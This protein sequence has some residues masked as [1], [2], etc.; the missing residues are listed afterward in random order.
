A[1]ATAHDLTK[2][3]DHQLGQ[4]S[5]LRQLAYQ[6]IVAEGLHDLTIAQHI[7][8]AMFYRGLQ[9]HEAVEIL[10]KHRLVED[11]RVLVRV[12]LEPMVNSAYMLIVGDDETARDFVKYPRFWNYFLMRDLKAIDESRFRKHVPVELEEDVRKEYEALLLRFKN[13]RNGEWCVDAKLYQ[14]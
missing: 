9:T 12:L 7:A 5:E 10:M 2:D 13:R 14:R 1:I 8:L 11:A 6:V 3:F 4:A